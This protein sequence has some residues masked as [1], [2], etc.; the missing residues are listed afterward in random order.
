MLFLLAALATS[1]TSPPIVRTAEPAAPP[2]CRTHMDYAKDRPLRPAPHRLD[3]E[4]SASEYLAVDRTINGC[5][6]PAIV[7]TGIGR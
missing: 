7:R 1:A 3:Q 4:P 6:V 2:S 5:F